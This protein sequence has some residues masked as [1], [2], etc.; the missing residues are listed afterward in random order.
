MNNPPTNSLFQFV[1]KAFPDCSLCAWVCA[2]PK[3]GTLNQDSHGPSRLVSKLKGQ[4]Q[5]LAYCR[6]ASKEAHRE[7]LTVRGHPARS[8]QSQSRNPRVPAPRIVP[9]L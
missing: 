3:A 4:V 6:K 9:I 1:L 2:S 5:S 8:R 7:A